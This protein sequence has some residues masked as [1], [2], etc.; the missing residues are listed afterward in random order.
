MNV[1]FSFSLPNRGVHIMVATTGRLMDMLDKKVVR[2]DVCRWVPNLL[3]IQKKWVTE[4]KLVLA[5]YFR[6]RNKGNVMVMKLLI[7]WMRL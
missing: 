3:L 4:E 1:L 5:S 6:H 7:Q 2:L